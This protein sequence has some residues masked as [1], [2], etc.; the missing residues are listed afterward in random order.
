MA[1]RR[2]RISGQ[3]DAR[4]I[5]MLRSPA[6][7]VLSLA[8]HRVLDRLVIELAQHGGCEN[9]RL[10]V[11]YGHFVEYGLHRH[12]IGPAIRE[13]EALGFIQVTERGRASAGE[14]RSPNYYRIT[15]AYCDKSDVPTHDWRRIKTI[16]E[17]ERIASAARDAKPAPRS[18]RDSGKPEFA[19]N[20]KPVTENANSSDGNHHRKP[21]LRVTETITTAPVAE[22]ITT[23]IS[24][25]GVR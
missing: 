9:G 20:K 12:A 19:K 6:Y 21:R 25:D 7:R 8:A 10:P 11:T 2:S 13:L 5:E 23:S 15:F 22:T 18:R 16:E 1:R 4:L 14:F 3:F 24:G 17:A